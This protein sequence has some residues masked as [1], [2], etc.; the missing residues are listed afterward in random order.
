MFK[1]V[2]LFLHLGLHVGVSKQDVHVSVY[3]FLLGVKYSRVVFNPTFSVI[4]LRKVCLFLLTASKL[5]QRILPVVGCSDTSTV[6]ESITSN[7][8]SY[9]S[10]KLSSQSIPHIIRINASI[11]HRY[12]KQWSNA[13]KQQYASRYFG[14]LLSQNGNSFI[15]Q[16]D[17]YVSKLAANGLLNSTG[18][19]ADSECNMF[20]N[21]LLARIFTRHG[22][23]VLLNKI[24][25]LGNWCTSYESIVAKLL[26]SNY[27]TDVQLDALVS[28]D[29]E[30]EIIAP[31]PQ[32]GFLGYYLYLILKIYYKAFQT[33]EVGTRLS[34]FKLDSYIRG[35]KKFYTFIRII[36]FFREFKDMPSILFYLDPS[37]NVLS[38]TFKYPICTIVLSD[39]SLKHNY[40]M[41]LI[42]TSFGTYLSRLFYSYIIINSYYLGRIL[43]LANILN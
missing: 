6:S 37:D 40:S 33:V 11:W 24:G 35:F 30:D 42:P 4:L 25:L 38:E 32:T 27:L 43:S 21:D 36:L 20:S 3:Y 15:S 9:N 39:G 14:S 7:T 28:E 41:Y 31:L 23:S 12:S 5:N 29:S 1:L 34:I 17:S 2:S 26:D 16:I 10:L 18:P 8:G 13:K 19:G 22:L